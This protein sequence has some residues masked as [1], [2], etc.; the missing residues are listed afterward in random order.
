[1]KTNDGFVQGYNAQIAVDDLSQIIV[2]QALT[3]QPPDVEHLVPMVEQIVD[4][5]GAAPRLLTADSGYYSERNV[6]R[7]QFRGTDVF[8][9]TERLR[10]ASQRV[11]VRG[12]APA[13]LT[14]KQR[15]ARKVHSLRGSRIYARRKAIV[16]PVFGQF[17][18]ARGLRGFLLRG[19]NKVRGEWALMCLGHNLRKLHKANR[20]L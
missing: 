13:N 20:A 1:M 14:A 19:T 6:K 5:C 15:M 8:I 2:A 16:E 10:R 4:N 3:N 11:P 17:K 9:A 7:I 18:M 12:R